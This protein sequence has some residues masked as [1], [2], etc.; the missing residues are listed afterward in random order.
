MMM[1]LLLLLL[2]LTSFNIKNHQRILTRQECAFHPI[3]HDKTLVLPCVVGIS[4]SQCRYSIFN[5]A[6]SYS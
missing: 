5:V 4:N 3:G 2:L 1:L 6:T